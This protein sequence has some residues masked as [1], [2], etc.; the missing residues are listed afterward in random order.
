MSLLK[1]DLIDF[2]IMPKKVLQ[3]DV[4]A[5][6]RSN[7]APRQSPRDFIRD[8]ESGKIRHFSWDCDISFDE[9]RRQVLAGCY[10]EK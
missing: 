1:K 9:F 5:R 4:D 10:D 8:V 3:K 6:F 2:G 7:T